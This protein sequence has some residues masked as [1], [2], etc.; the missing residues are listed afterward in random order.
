[1][2]KAYQILMDRLT[3]KGKMPKLHI[4]DNECS[5]EMKIV[6]KGKDMDS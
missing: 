4:L 3:D 6:T 2:A 1:M 5:E